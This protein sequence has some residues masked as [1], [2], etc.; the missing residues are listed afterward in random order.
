[1]YIAKIKEDKSKNKF[2][3]PAWKMSKH[4]EFWIWAESFIIIVLIQH[5]PKIIFFSNQNSNFF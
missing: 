4:L 2:T 3:V 5:Q 1:M